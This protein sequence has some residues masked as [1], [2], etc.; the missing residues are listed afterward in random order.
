MVYNDGG[1]FTEYCDKPYDQN[2]YK[3]FLQNGNCKTF[4]DYTTMRAVWYNMREH[5]SHV[6][7]VP[8][9]KTK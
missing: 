6:E 9:K 1:T 5:V 4:D 8:R 3:V 7:I 2:K